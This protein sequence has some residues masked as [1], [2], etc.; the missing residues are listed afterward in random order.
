[1]MLST[2][3]K[4]ENGQLDRGNSS[5]PT[6][7]PTIWFYV[8]QEDFAVAQSPDGSTEFLQ[9]PSC[10]WT[11]LT[12]LRL[13]R[14]IGHCRLTSVLPTAGLLIAHRISVPFKYRPPTGLLFICICGDAT[15]HPYAHIQVV[16]N[17]AQIT[18]V[19]NSFQI[20]FWPQRDVIPRELGRG[21]KFEN[22]DYFGVPE[23]LSP[24]LHSP[25]WLDFLANLGCRWRL[26]EFHEWNDYSTTDVV[27][28]VRSFDGDPCIHKP[29]SKLLNAW[30]GEVPAVLGPESAYQ[31]LRR[32]ESDFLEVRSFAELKS[33]MLTLSRDSELRRRMRENGR[34]R[35]AEVTAESITKRW[36]MF[37]SAVAIP[38]YEE[39]NRSGRLRHLSF[40]THSYLRVRRAGLIHRLRN[41]K[42][43]KWQ[44][45]IRISSRNR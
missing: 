7:S 30:R 36:E 40:V 23:H 45:A 10:H 29:A 42:K 6:G 5:G 4:V 31:V 44:V 27:A 17:P 41:L 2:R 33:T 24:E 8:P 19:R 22:I 12:Y 3:F 37:I 28:A 35:S 20:P 32:S 13:K 34:R 21:D 9:R 39:I 43:G 18:S 1:M 15:P 25:E 16:Q 38:K 14:H 26:R 11:L